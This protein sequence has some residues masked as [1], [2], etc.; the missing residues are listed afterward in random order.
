M[1]ERN[2]KREALAFDR[3]KLIQAGALAALGAATT[4][5]NSA[6]ADQPAANAIQ[7]ENR[8]Q[9][10]TDWQLT[11]VRTDP[12]Q[13]R[14]SRLIEGYCSHT[15]ID[16]GESL[17]LF[18]SAE[19]ANDVYVDVYRM[20]YYGGTGGRFI[21]RLGPF[22][23]SPQPEPE[24]G[25]KRVRECRWE[26]TTTLPIPDDWLSGVYLFKLSTRKH[27]Y[28]SYAITIVKDRRQADVLFQCSDHTWQAYNKWPHEYSLYDADPPHSLS[29]TTRVSFD[30]PYA[31][32]WQVVDQP[33]T[34]GSGEFLCWEF[35]LAYWLEQ[36]GYDVTYISNQDTHSDPAGLQRGKV[37]L[38]VGHDEYW[39]LEMY[40]NMLQAIQ[41]GLNVAFLSGNT[42]CFVAPFAASSDG[43]PRRIFHRGGRY[44]GLLEAEKGQMGPFDMEGPNEN[45]LIGARTISPFN[46]SDDWIVTKADHW[47]F[48]GTGLKN[49]DR[50]PGLVGWEFHGDP[51]PIPG[52]EVVAEGNAINS[53]DHVGHW[54]STVYPGPKGNWVF[55]A[56]TIYWSLGLSTP[57]G[58]MSPYAHFSHPHGPEPRVGQITENFLKK[59]GV[60]KT[61]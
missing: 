37:F 33:L 46:G 2:E 57:P 21:T 56:S 9:G 17:T 59:C 14:R 47:L 19:P 27:R 8:K 12:K 1:S 30:R 24:V 34:L 50:F 3:R 38:S 44:G 15:S 58:V 49:G 35:P 45:L 18:L 13:S 25:P 52:L 26:P 42:C 7:A 23:V 51:A 61:V 5:G 55:N 11:Y 31:K 22:A 39:S 60:G 16:A 53:G 29:G 6:Q 4:R 40:Q 28:Q 36:H 48:E 41:D 10:T 54:T 43:R 32:Y 20:G